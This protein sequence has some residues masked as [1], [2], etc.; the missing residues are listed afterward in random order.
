MAL[1]G[2][3]S[4]DVAIAQF[5]RV[6]NSLTLVAEASPSSGSG[7]VKWSPDGEYVASSF[8]VYSFNRTNNTLT[9]VA[10][11]PSGGANSVDWSQMGTIWQL[12]LGYCT[13][14]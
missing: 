2:Q 5:N 12:G 9:S 8:Q 14:I 11:I 10:M 13:D 3:S 6:A 7:T 1:V 4:S